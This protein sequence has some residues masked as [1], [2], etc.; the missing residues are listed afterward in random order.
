[1][2]ANAMNCVILA[3]T[4]GKT[5]TR[6]TRAILHRARDTYESQICSS[7]VGWYLLHDGVMSGRLIG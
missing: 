6:A 1:M 2:D 7:G 3:L 4:W 5:T